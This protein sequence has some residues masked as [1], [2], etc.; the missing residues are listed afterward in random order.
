MTELFTDGLGSE[1]S[2]GDFG[3]DV[4]ELDTKKMK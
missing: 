3:K 4:G 1:F 2:R